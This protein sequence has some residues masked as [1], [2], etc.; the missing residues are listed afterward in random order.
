[1]WNLEVQGKTAVCVALDGQVLGVLGIADV[2]KPE[3]LL[4]VNALQ[5]M[6]IDVWMVTGDNR[7][8]AEAIAEE[9]GIPKDHVVSGAMPQD[10]V[11]TTHQLLPVLI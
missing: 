2:P 4:T 7:T 10:K 1:M 6:S 9:F 5:N 11:L 3:A 8:T